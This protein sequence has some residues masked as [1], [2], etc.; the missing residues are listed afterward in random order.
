MIIYSSYKMSLGMQE[1]APVHC[2]SLH[3]PFRVIRKERNSFQETMMK[4]K[5]KI[6]SKV[7]DQANVI[8]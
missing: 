6:F 2:R 1:G 5:F 3:S 7:I 4:E 8:V